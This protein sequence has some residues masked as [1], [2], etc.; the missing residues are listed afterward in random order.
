M[1]RIIDTRDPDTY[2]SF[3]E[4]ERICKEARAKWDKVR[5]DFKIDI[6]KKLSVL[7][8]EID[9]DTRLVNNRTY[10]DIY[11][12]MNGN[13]VKLGCCYES[14]GE[15]V[16]KTTKKF[17]KKHFEGFLDNIFGK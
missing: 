1:G 15:D 11:L 10:T 6:N 14:D 13:R 3:S 16:D 9:F 17:L 4:Y 8:A 12:I 5:E 7:N 2:M